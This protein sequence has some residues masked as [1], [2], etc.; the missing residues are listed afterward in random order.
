[1][2][3]SET[4]M[5]QGPAQA[6]SHTLRPA[7]HLTTGGKAG[8]SYEFCG[9]ETMLRKR[10]AD[11]LIAPLGEA[12]LIFI[13]AIAGWASHQPLVFASLGPTAYELIETPHRRS[14]QPYS[15]LVGHL[16]GIGSGYAALFV[17]G[18]WSAAPVSA[19]GVPL[20]RVAA[21]VLAAG[22]TAF[23][24]L[25]L[26]ASQPAALSTTLLIALGLMQAPKDA[27]I[28]MG[29]VVLMVL[30]GEPIRMW[31]LNRQKQQEAEAPGS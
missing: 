23:T 14:A 21:A 7:R 16:L 25:L 11:L 4:R 9:S 2:E 29:A 20:H 1:M 31:R 12:L 18:C 3:H 15:V 6:G 26:R 19:G 10:S 24:T 5:R 30:F 8:G 27:G 28:L 17:A 13:A 22:L